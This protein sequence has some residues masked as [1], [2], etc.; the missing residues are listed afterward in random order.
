MTA[1]RPAATASETERQVLRIAT[2][3]GLTLA[4]TACS[5]V[6]LMGIALVLARRLGRA[7]VGLYAQAY[8]VLTLLGV[9]SLSGVRTAVTRFVAVHWAE[10]D[11]GALRGTTRLSVTATLGAAAGLGVALFAAAPLLARAVFHDPALVLPLRFVAV[12]LPA[13]SFMDTALATIQGFRS[14]RAFALISLVFEPVAKAALTCLL[15]WWGLG[16]PGAMAALLVSNVAGAGL[17]GVALRRRLGRVTVPPVYRPRELFGFSMASWMASMATTGLI[18]AD[19]LLL[20][21]FRN[22]AEVGVYNVATRLVLLAGLAM[23]AINAA[24]GPRIAD[25]HHR[26][27][28]QSLQQAYRAAE[29]W[30]LRLYLPGFALIVAFPDDLLGLFGKA[31]EA[32]AA[33]TVILAVG[34]LVDNA[35]GPCG[36]M[37]NMSGRP[38][39]TMVDNIAVLIVNVVL[40]LLL[41]PRYG[42]VGSAVAWAVSL[43]LVNLARL[44]Q[45]WVLL[46]MLPFNRATLKGLVAGVGSLA[47][48]LLTRWLLDPPLRLPVGA[49][50]LAAVYVGLLVVLGLGWEDR[51]VLR[52]LRRRLRRRGTKRPAPERDIQVV[53]VVS[54]EDGDARS[55][56]TACLAAVLARCGRGVLVVSGDLRGSGLDRVYGT[57]G[58]PGLAEYL[59]GANGNVWLSLIAVRN[60]V[61][62]LPAGRPRADPAE[63]LAGPRLA[64]LVEEF[65]RLG[66]IVVVDTPG[67]RWSEE[68]LP[69]LSAADATVV[70]TGAGAHLPAVGALIAELRRTGFET[71]GV[72]LDGR[73]PA[74]PILTAPTGGRP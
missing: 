21:V 43:V 13:V 56:L 32:G 66:L 4:A 9:L 67:G 47:V 39:W 49:I 18:W 2:G 34:K 33:V 23:P 28:S 38:V 19:T 29:S 62:L 54:A 41:I 24:F 44:L 72:A 5:Q 37:L 14:M 68:S 1:G 45:V 25:L 64:Q 65:R 26:G 20:G 57:Q 16:L 8:A 74:L 17:A 73:R 6:A 35:T 59:E 42:I 71:V 70:A 27:R 48:G 10:G 15:L 30:T 22:S 46:R 3:G 11:L 7:E 31:F 63:L 60:N 51:V 69:L 36:L 12:A 53:A 40:N 52:E 55:L 50:L 58:R 61:L